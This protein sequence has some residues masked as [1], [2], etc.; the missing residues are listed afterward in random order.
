MDW[1]LGVF[2]VISIMATFV[3]IFLVVRFAYVDPQYVKL[4]K[5]YED[6]V[7]GLREAAKNDEPG[8]IWMRVNAIIHNSQI[9]GHYKLRK[10]DNKR[11][12]LYSDW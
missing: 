4:I 3:G 10:Q 6:R 12:S 8:R 2:Q 5:N 11:D 7:L 9:V 1:A